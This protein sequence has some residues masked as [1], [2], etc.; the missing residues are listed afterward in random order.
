MFVLVFWTRVWNDRVL[1]LQPSVQY[2]RVHERLM[3][4]MADIS[5]VVGI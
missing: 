5:V 1:V 2:D 3:L 4:L